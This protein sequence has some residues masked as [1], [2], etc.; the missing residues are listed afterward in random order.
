MP[1][2]VVKVTWDEENEQTIIKTPYSSQSIKIPSINFADG[3]T[4]WNYII[5]HQ[6]PGGI[7]LSKTPWVLDIR[8]IQG[9]YLLKYTD[10]RTS[11]A[12]AAF[13]QAKRGVGSRI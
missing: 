6:N 11:H 12:G 8:S 7:A 4:G 5:L 2:S 1:K 9:S 10:V 13:H 3:I